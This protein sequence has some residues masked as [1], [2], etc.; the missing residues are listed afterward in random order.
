MKIHRNFKKNPGLIAT[1]YMLTQRS[2]RRDPRLEVQDKTYQV[3]AMP[4]LA[5]PREKVDEQR[6]R[7]KR[8]QSISVIGERDG[9][10]TFTLGISR[11]VHLRIDL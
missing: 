10:S 3:D 7:C 9:S 8:W 11:V 1:V 2:R 6:H 5:V 4:G